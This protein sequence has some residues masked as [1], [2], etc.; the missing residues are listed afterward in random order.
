MYV[1]NKSSEYPQLE[2]WRETGLDKRGSWS[3]GQYIKHDRTVHKFRPDN[4]IEILRI[5]FRRR[6]FTLF[7][8]FIRSDAQTYCYPFQLKKEISKL[9]SSISA[10]VEELRR[11]VS[12]THISL[13]YYTTDSLLAKSMNNLVSLKLCNNTSLSEKT[14]DFLKLN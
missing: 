14:I 10:K 1:P 3:I 9:T 7:K 11:I 12:I 8:R 6:L 5:F 13:I 2:F 4:C